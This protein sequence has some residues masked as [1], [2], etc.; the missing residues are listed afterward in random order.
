MKEVI[1]ISRGK[2]SRMVVEIT[3]VKGKKNRKGEPFKLSTTKHLSLK[4]KKKE[5]TSEEK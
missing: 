4:S 3:T 5:K 1:E 2:K